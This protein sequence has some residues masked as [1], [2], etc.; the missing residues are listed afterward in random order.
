MFADEAF[1]VIAASLVFHYLEHWEPTLIELRR[2]MVPGGLLAISTHHPTMD[3]QFHGGS[4]FDTRH[5]SETWRKQGVSATASFWRRPLMA[6]VAEFHK[7]GFAIEELVEPM[8]VAEW[9]ERFPEAYV[10]LTTAPRFFFFR[11]R[12]G[13]LSRLEVPC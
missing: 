3:W 6:V 2:V 9:K 4:Y 11:L 12:S 10:K 8:P 13:A 5:I 1:D 7:T